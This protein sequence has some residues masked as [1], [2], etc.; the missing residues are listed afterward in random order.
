M[1]KR[2]TTIGWLRSQQRL[3]LLARS[4]DS[5]L[6]FVYVPRSAR[7]ADAPLRYFAQALTTSQILARERP[8][9]VLVQNPPIFLA[10]LVSAYCRLAG[11][12]YIIDSHSGAFVDSKWRWSLGLHRYLSRRAITTLVHNRDQE[13]IVSQWRCP[14]MLLAYTPGK[15]SPSGPSKMNAGFRVAV[16]SSFNADERPEMVFQ[17]ARELPEVEFYM[18]GDAARVSPEVMSLR[19]DNCHLTGYLPYEEYFELL[20]SAD[21]VMAL[22][23]RDGTLLMGGFEAV[24][25]GR[26]LITSDWPVLRE[27]FHLGTVHIPNSPEGIAEGVRRAQTQQRSLEQGMTRIREELEADWAHKIAELRYRV[28]LDPSPQP[29]GVLR[30]S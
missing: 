29:P 14:Y 5:S 27:F 20:R 13:R 11:A 23:N 10:L 7:L 2:V 17:A 12:G 9:A 3:E 30:Q 19:P 22:T 8:L 26:P 18:T 28:G 24:S 6:H 25:A 21:A 4:L 1:T 15:D 16:V